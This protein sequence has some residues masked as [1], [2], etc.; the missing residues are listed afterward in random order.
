M[1]VCSLQIF[2]GMFRNECPILLIMGL[3]KKHNAED[4]RLKARPVGR[5]PKAR[6]CVIAF[7]HAR[8]SMQLAC[9]DLH[10][11]RECRFCRSKNLSKQCLDSDFWASPEFM[12]LNQSCPSHEI[13]M[14]ARMAILKF[15]ILFG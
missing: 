8:F 3:H 12:I 10:G 2:Q 9:F 13:S 4:V 1:K 14:L 11:W 5:C 7:H 15:Y 6:L